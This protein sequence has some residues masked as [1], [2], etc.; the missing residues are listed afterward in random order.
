MRRSSPRW[1]SAGTDRRSARNRASMATTAAATTASRA[2][3]ASGNASTTPAVATPASVNQ[4]DLVTVTMT[5]SAGRRPIVSHRPM[6]KKVPS[7]FS[8]MDCLSE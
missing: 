5:V 4:G 3:H 8:S 7:G 2:S 1:I 6:T